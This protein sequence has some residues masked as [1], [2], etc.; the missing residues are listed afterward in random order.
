[1]KATRFYFRGIAHLSR[2]ERYMEEVCDHYNVV[3]EYFGNVLLASSEAARILLSLDERKSDHKVEAIADRD[4][5]ALVVRLSLISEDAETECRDE[6]D[7]EVA[8]LKLKRELF[9]VSS[10][11]DETD[12]SETGNVIQLKF[13]IS[14]MDM[15]RSLSRVQQLRDYWS[16]SEIPVNKSNG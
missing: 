15:D 2:F 4:G 8:K 14:S 16:K 7:I 6:I 12:I 10:L 5:K 13:F 11:A 1:M 3:N 9:I